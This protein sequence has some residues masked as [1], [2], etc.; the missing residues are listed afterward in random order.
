[1]RRVFRT[2]VTSLVLGSMALWPITLVLWVH[3]GHTLRKSPDGRTT[4]RN[5]YGHISVTHSTWVGNNGIAQFDRAWR[6]LGF[7]VLEYSMVDGATVTVRRFHVWPVTALNLAVIGGWV[8]RRR[9]R[10]RVAEASPH[11]RCT[12]CGYDPRATRDRCPECGATAKREQ[13][14]P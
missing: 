1:M 6:V 14:T 7:G 9:M 5:F 3:G 11:R 2:I 13:V 12:S 10:A 8:A 4:V